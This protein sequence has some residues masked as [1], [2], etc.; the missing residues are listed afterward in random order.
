M[1]FAL[2][3]QAIF[4]PVLLRQAALHLAEPVVVQARGIDM[5]PGD[6][7]TH[8]RTH[9]EPEIHASVGAIGIIETEK[10]LLIHRLRLF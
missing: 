7:R 9:A 6:G 3:F 8:G 10:Y 1:N 4:G 2:F 5:A